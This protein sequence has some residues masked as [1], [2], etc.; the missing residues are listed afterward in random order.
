M[1]KY[2]AFAQLII[3][4]RKSLGFS[5]SKS[6]HSTLSDPPVEYQSWTHIE[7]GR[8]LPKPETA[9]A[10]GEIMAIPRKEIIV[11]YAQ[12]LFQDE[13]SL[14]IIDEFSAV[15]SASI[16]PENF[17]EAVRLDKEWYTL[18]RHQIEE[19]A[20]EPRLFD[21]ISAHFPKEQMSEREIASKM[22]YDLQETRK[23]LGK[24]VGLRL[25]ES[26]NSMVSKKYRGVKLAQNEDNLSIRR[27][28]LLHDIQKRFNKKS[29][30]SNW[31]VQLSEE[32]LNEILSQFDVLDAKCSLLHEKSKKDPG[33]ETFNIVCMMNPPSMH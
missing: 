21:I 6:Y 22:G 16:S 24:L 3:E 33:S 11:A 30:L 9:I 31:M 26:K 7:S 18:N 28:I 1:M 32:G 27:N 29:V 23:L 15:G 4:K 17:R 25:L 5:T 13:T 12:D 19:F 20:R 10:I 8:R 14:S 2:K